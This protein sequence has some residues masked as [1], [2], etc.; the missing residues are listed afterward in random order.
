MDRDISCLAEV[1]PSVNYAWCTFMM[2]TTR[3]K[4]KSGTG[5]ISLR[6]YVTSWYN[7][8]VVP[9]PSDTNYGSNFSDWMVKVMNQRYVVGSSRDCFISHELNIWVLQ[10]TESKFSGCSKP[11]NP[12]QTQQFFR[13]GWQAT[14]HLPFWKE[15]LWYVHVKAKMVKGCLEMNQNWCIACSRSW[16]WCRWELNHALGTHQSWI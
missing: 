9:L 10:T 13:N 6:T 5:N 1:G 15:R 16:I 12:D 3:C 7:I 2:S 14:W 4:L 8:E 11:L